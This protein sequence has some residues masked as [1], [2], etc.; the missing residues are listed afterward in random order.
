MP[1][2]VLGL[3]PTAVSSFHAWAT[4]HFGRSALG[5]ECT[6][7]SVCDYETTSSHASGEL[8]RGGPQEALAGCLQDLA[9]RSLLPALE[10]RVRALH[11]Q[12]RCSWIRMD[13]TA[14]KV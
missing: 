12:A 1:L 10:G 3:T 14:C 2:C 13:P 7:V 5:G 4:Q 8:R 11:H 9:V 6:C